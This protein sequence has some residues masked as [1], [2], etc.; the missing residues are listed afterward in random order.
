MARISTIVMLAG[1]VMF[2]I[3]EPITSGLGLLVLLI[4][5][6]MRLLSSA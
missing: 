4:G 5:V 3:P 6:A 1:V 2:F